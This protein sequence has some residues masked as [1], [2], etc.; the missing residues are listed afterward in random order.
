MAR[1]NDSNIDFVKQLMEYSRYGALAQLF[2]LDAI[3]KQCDRILA[4]GID[5][6]REQFG[7]NSMVSP[8]AWFGVE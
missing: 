4:A 3:E 6:V 8:E 1:K 2:V 5:K 7:E